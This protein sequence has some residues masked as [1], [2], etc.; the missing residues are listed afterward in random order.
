MGVELVEVLCVCEKGREG[1][2]QGICLRIE[3]IIEDFQG[4]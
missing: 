2:D 4:K 1:E 3:L